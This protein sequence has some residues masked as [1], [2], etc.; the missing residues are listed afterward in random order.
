MHSKK[1]S[2]ERRLTFKQKKP[3]WNRVF[4]ETKINPLLLGCI[5][6]KMT[7][8]A[9]DFSNFLHSI[10]IVKS[11]WSTPSLCSQ[12]GDVFVYDPPGSPSVSRTYFYSRASRLALSS[13]SRHSLHRQYWQKWKVQQKT[14]G[15]GESR[16]EVSPIETT[17]FLSTNALTSIS[18]G[19]A[20]FEGT[21]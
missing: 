19:I 3:N 15:L 21:K 11:L 16:G 8:F 9:W 14:E 6:L 10:L 2:K 18:I 5:V 12:D 13:P 7:M 17:T 1:Q 4:W 20:S